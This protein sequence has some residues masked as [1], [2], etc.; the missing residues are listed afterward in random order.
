MVS[1]SAKAKKNFTNTLML[2]HKSDNK[3]PMPWKG[4]KDAYKIWLSEIILQQTRVEQGLSY[5][6]K[7]ISAFPKLEDLA[8]ANEEKVYKLWEGLGYYSRAK[9]LHFTAKF[10]FYDLKNIFPDTYEKLLQL[11]GVGPYTAAAIASFAYSLPYAVLDGNVFRVL[12]RVFNIETATD[13]TEGKNLFGKLAQ[14]VI[15]INEPALYNQA[16]MDFGATVCKPVPVCNECVM[17]K[18]CGAYKNAT[19]NIL[20]VKEKRLKQKHRW[21]YY[22][23]F[24]NDESLLIHKRIQKDIWQNLYEFYLYE[25]DKKN[26]WNNNTITEWLYKQ[27]GI[28]DAL[29]IS[30]SE[31]Q[32]QKL[33]HQTIE[34]KIIHIQLRKIPASLSHLE[35]VKKYEIDKLAFP[36]FVRKG[37]NI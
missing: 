24:E 32:T 30:I 4:E 28:S 13:T 26:E 29:V 1:Y 22:F 10:I 36:V 16:I 15:D 23:V 25:A 11:K 18:H 27:L 37:F 33:T 2:W 12:S 7:F 34:G 20:P 35:K 21:F 6:E 8:K 3:R 19:V 9:N 14:S 5:Y 17:Q 31:N